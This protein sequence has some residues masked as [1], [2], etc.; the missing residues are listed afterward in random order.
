M[1]RT[2]NLTDEQISL[3]ENL[4]KSTKESPA[5]IQM[6]ERAESIDAEIYSLEEVH[7]RLSNVVETIIPD[8][9]DGKVIKPL[10]QDWLSLALQVQIG[11]NMIRR[12][13]ILRYTE[14]EIGEAIDREMILDYPGD[15]L[16][17]FSRRA[18]EEKDAELLSE[19][20][21]SSGAA[22]FKSDS[23]ASALL[24]II[25]G[26]LVGVLGTALTVGV[27]VR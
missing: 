22:W 8:T 1:D 17:F 13:Q 5:S 24:G 2:I 23:I 26:L 20:S 10:L 15:W 3:L 25:G 11:M 16:S 12:D 14:E 4:L 9:E 19:E 7:D 27:I 18:N 21:E 6:R